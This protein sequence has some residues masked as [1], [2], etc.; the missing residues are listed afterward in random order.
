MCY[1]FNKILG[2]TIVSRSKSLIYK[3]I[4]TMKLRVTWLIMLAC[5][6]WAIQ[7]SVIPTIAQIALPPQC[8]ALPINYPTLASYWRWLDA[9]TVVF[10]VDQ[11]QQPDFVPDVPP[12]WY[13]YTLSNQKLT[14]LS[15][16]PFQMLT[17]LIPSIAPTEILELTDLQAG[18]SGL[19]EY[20]V[21]SPLNDLLIYPRSG[22]DGGTY[23][24]FDR[25]RGTQVDLGISTRFVT[26]QATF[27]LEVFWSSDQQIVVAGNSFANSIFPVKLI[28]INEGKVVIQNLTDMP[29]LSRYKEYPFAIGGL[30]PDGDTIVIRA[31]FFNQT[32]LV[33]ISEQTID[34]VDFFLVG[35]PVVWTAPDK[36]VTGAAL[37]TIGYTIIEYDMTK[38]EIRTLLTHDQVREIGAS[39]LSLSPD[40]RYV[41]GLWTDDARINSQFV[42]C[43]TGL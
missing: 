36:F 29:V 2:R 27:D 17:N 37:G 7:S 43:D 24:L 41:V 12:V 15:E 32:W 40:G 26:G 25:E 30:S 18:N 28:Q 4:T 42:V 21:I 10:S 34:E 38:R 31:D 1:L 16:S 5:C 20:M 3:E 13:K 11:G 23:W 8:R 6:A 22:E 39:S 35:D 14:E 33:S 19:Y 9:D